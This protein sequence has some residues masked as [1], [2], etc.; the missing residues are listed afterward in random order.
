MF[1]PGISPSVSASIALMKVANWDGTSHDIE[2]VLVAAFDA[3]DYLD[4]VKNLQEQSIDPTSYINNLDQVS[5]SPISN[6]RA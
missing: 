1:A 6:R 3:E 4:C 5:P 2:Q